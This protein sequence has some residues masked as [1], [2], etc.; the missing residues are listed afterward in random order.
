MSYHKVL[1]R[2]IYELDVINE[3][4]YFGST[5]SNNLSIDKD[6]DRR[7]GRHLPLFA[8]NEELITEESLDDKASCW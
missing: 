5:I 1:H 7:I 8:F 2:L 4:R 3:V 6:V